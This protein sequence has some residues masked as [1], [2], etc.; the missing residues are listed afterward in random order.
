MAISFS[1]NRKK[2]KQK[3]KNQNQKQKKPKPKTKTQIMGPG[4]RYH[5]LLL[6]TDPRRKRSRREH[7]IQVWGSD[8][9]FSISKWNQVKGL[10][11]CFLPA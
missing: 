4:A 5:P 10:E 2:Q 6:S 8:E 9:I 3:Q 1:V 7:A 11:F